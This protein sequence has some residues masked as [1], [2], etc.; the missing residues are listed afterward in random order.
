MMAHDAGNNY[1]HCGNPRQNKTAAFVSVL[2]LCLVLFFSGTIAAQNPP[3]NNIDTAT[4]A[5][6]F[7]ISD[8]RVNG[9][10]RIKPPA[11]FNMLSVTA[12]D[13]I[14]EFSIRS[15]MRALFESG[16]FS[17]IRM[18]R[19][20]NELIIDLV[21]NPSI[22]SIDISGNKAIQTD[23]LIGGLKDAGIA[24][25]EVFRRAVLA[26]MKSEL[27]RL[28]IARG[29]Y[30]VAI[31]TRVTPVPPDKIAI[32]LDIEEG[33]VSKIAEINLIGN[34]AFSDA[35]LL[36]L[37]ELR[38]TDN[39]D[40]F[41]RKSKYSREKLR[42]DLERVE[43]YCQDRGYA[44]FE[45]LS[46]QV[47]ISKDRREIY[48]S[49]NIKEGE[50]FTVSGVKLIG[51]I[52]Y[53]TP[54][55]LESLLVVEPNTVF[56]RALVTSSQERVVH[57]LSEAGYSQADV[58]SDPVIDEENG[59]VEIRFMV[60]VGHRTY[61]RRINFY[62]NTNTQDEVLRRELRQI[63]GSW[64]SASQME[65]SKI[66]LERLG[67]FSAVEME[68][69]P[70]PGVDDQVDL[71]FTVTERPSGS[72]SASIGYAEGRGIILSSSLEESNI[73]GTGN[74]LKATVSHSDY[75]TSFNLDY[76]DPY[77]TPEGI[78]RNLVVYTR[79]TDYDA[80]NIS[81]YSTANRGV[82]TIFGFPL[83]ET[84]QMRTG[85]SIDYTNIENAPSLREVEYED[86][87]QQEGREHLNYKAEV[88]WI[89]SRLNRGIFPTAG[90]H[91]S[92]RFEFS[93]PGS[94][95]QFYKASYFGQVYRPLSDNF[96]LRLKTRLG[97]TDA[98]GSSTRLPLYENFFTGGFGSV[99]GY[100]TN[101]IGSRATT[102]VS[103]DPNVYSLGNS[104][105]GNIL[106][107]A[108]AELIVNLPFIEESNSVRTVLFVDSGQVYNTNC[109]AES[110]YCIEPDLTEMRASF[111]ASVVWLSPLGPL[112]FSYSFP[113]NE[114]EFDRTE[115][116]QFEI[117]GR[118]Y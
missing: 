12:G 107:E 91:Q 19:E 37:M 23:G 49:I 83:N 51:E 1:L 14:D 114:G 110:R 78:S 81:R 33:T 3:A 42:G 43:S 54:E 15:Q 102:L 98:Y 25:G 7:Q 105:G 35:E 53:L 36:G 26:G 9:L 75:Q 20:G 6:E 113:F 21:E 67:F 90:H 72:I 106:V 60:D 58:G 76:T 84:E 2:W 94:D 39:D 11:V 108:G 66:R 103:T 115:A 13:I 38:S 86:F 17:D 4:P 95:L 101:T 82:G 88:T 118:L 112:S 55:V 70:V 27:Q 52:G 16:E 45:I 8:I 57:A 71:N 104:I 69:A 92:V 85:F 99:R 97:F 46:T 63:E 40:I 109:P 10:R 44:S 29:R 87:F 116:F 80:L 59:T 32:E 74:T 93:V 77:V 111:G 65:L 30:S 48:I 64:V 96:S 31:E 73:F 47:T 100:K 24:E 18:G 22:E 34:K 117:G 68:T 5:S 28:Y 79:Q 50:Q 61:V 62:G 56:S 41:G 89:G